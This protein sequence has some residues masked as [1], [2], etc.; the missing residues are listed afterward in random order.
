LSPVS[1]ESVS[2]ADVRFPT[3]ST[4]TTEKQSKGF[5]PSN[6][7]SLPVSLSSAVDEDVQEVLL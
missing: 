3:P 7:R 6:H 4:K 5:F 1:C 2:Y